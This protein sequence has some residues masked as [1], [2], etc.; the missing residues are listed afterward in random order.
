VNVRVPVV[1]GTI[2][3]WLNTSQLPMTYP[4]VDVN[5]SSLIHELGGGSTIAQMTDSSN[6]LI[7]TDPEFIVISM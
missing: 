1:A 6:S 3:V 4:V 7:F 5:N 2:D